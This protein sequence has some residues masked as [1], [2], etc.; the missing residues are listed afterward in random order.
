MDV[1]ASTAAA[2]AMP[3][4]MAGTSFNT[5]QAPALE[6]NARVVQ[7]TQRA[8]Y[9]AGRAFFQNGNQWVD[10]NVSQQNAGKSVRIKFAS[11]EYFAL[12]AQHPKA[13]PLARVRRET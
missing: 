7:Y 11:D 5:V 13:R 8:K 9:V 10:N 1:P 12:L 3:M 2:P 4:P 6:A